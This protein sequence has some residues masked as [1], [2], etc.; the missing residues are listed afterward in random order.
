MSAT[1]L[2]CEPLYAVLIGAIA[3]GAVSSTAVAAGLNPSAS[4]PLLAARRGL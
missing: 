4:E 2:N 3:M 1:K